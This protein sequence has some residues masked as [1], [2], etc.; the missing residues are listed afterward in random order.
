[1]TVHPADRGVRDFQPNSHTTTDS[2][3]PVPSDEFSAQVG[4]QGPQ[5]IHQFD[6]LAQIHHIL[7]QVYVQS[8]AKIIRKVNL[9]LP[10]PLYRQ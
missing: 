1:M 7:L 9:Q 5:P 8:I 6:P 2:G 4:P 3:Q 10:K